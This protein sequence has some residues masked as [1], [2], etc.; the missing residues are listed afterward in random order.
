MHNLDKLDGK[1]LEHETKKFIPVSK[2]NPENCSSVDKSFSKY[3]FSKAK[4]T[5][6][7]KTTFEFTETKILK[8]KL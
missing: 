5:R 3:L 1:V 2:A 6:F 7:E 4:L 8:I